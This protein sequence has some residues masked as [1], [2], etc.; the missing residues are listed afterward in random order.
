MNTIN[1][2][3]KY[4]REWDKWLYWWNKEDVRDFFNINTPMGLLLDYMSRKKIKK[5]KADLDM[6]HLPVTSYMMLT[7]LHPTKKQNIHLK[8]FGI[9]KNRLKTSMMTL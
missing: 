3:N 7:A 6:M 8:N 9:C 4:A 1:L 2:R 5:G